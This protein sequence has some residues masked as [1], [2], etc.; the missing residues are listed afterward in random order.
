MECDKPKDC[1]ISVVSQFRLIFNNILGV[2]VAKRDVIC[3]SLSSVFSWR[4]LRYFLV[5]H[6]TYA[7]M[8]VYVCL[9]TRISVE[10]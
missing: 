7:C 5:F 4:A 10:I 9:I 3:F 1:P 2:C 6:V 8:C